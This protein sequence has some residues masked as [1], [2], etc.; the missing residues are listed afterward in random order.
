MVWTRVVT[1][2]T[3]H[4]LDFEVEYHMNAPA[5]AALIGGAL[6]LSLAAGVIPVLMGRAK[7]PAGAADLR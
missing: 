4:S 1:D 6:V 7:V 2:A 5:A 3:A